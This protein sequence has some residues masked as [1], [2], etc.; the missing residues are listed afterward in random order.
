MNLKEQN[1]HEKF[2][3]PRRTSIHLSFHLNHYQNHYTSIYQAHIRASHS[4]CFCFEALISFK[5]LS[6]NMFSAHLDLD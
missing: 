4:S 6:C 1:S 5:T 2:C 3:K